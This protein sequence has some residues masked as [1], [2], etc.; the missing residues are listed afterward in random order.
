MFYV[1]ILKKYHGDDDYII[2]WNLVLLDENLFYEE[3]Q[4]ANIKRNVQKLR[5]KET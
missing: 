5:T 1:L 2:H 3:E 4:I